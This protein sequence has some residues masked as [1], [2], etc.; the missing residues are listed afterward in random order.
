M[1]TK[2]T[3]R[4]KGTRTN[5]VEELIEGWAKHELFKSKNILKSFFSYVLGPVHK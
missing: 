3:R 4:S 5:H 1:Y 2:K